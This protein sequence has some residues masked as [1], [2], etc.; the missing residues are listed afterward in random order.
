MMNKIKQILIAVAAIFMVQTA[1]AQVQIGG[2]ASYLKGTGD[3]DANLWGGGIHAKF[4]IGNRLALGGGFRTFPTTKEDV[5]QNGSSKVRTTDALSQ[6]YSSLDF[7]TS[8]K[9]SAIQPFVGVDAGVS[10]SNRTILITSGSNTV[11]DQKNKSTFFYLAPKAGLNIAVSPAFGL[12]GQASYGLTFGDGETVN[13]G[14]L[15]NPVETKPVDKF[16]IF[17]V[18][19]Y[20]RLT[21][22]K[23]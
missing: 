2:N 11:I 19:V 17:D 22:A 4:F 10:I 14:Q 9:Q 20:L 12:F 21:G 1:S 6:I 18:G 3:N 16:F 23:K 13:I 8:K 15:P 5:S 7:L